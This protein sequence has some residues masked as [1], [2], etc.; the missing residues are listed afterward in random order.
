MIVRLTARATRHHTPRV[1]GWANRGRGGEL[2]LCGLAA[3]A[4]YPATGR[5]HNGQMV[6]ELPATANGSTWHDTRVHSEGGQVPR[7]GLER[8]F[9]TQCAHETGSP[10]NINISTKRIR[11]C[12]PNEMTQMIQ[13][14]LQRQ[15]TP[16]ISLL[17]KCYSYDKSFTQDTSSDRG[18]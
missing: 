1:R 13:P 12:K 5:S 7:E 10:G 15:T 2:G 3:R 8:L 16:I 4:Q 14:H 18:C 17:F 11:Y 6:S 9:E